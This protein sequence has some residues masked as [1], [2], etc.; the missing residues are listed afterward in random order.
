MYD[1]IQIRTYLGPAGQQEAVKNLL[2]ACRIPS[3]SASV[4]EQ[5][6][7]T[8]YPGLAITSTYVDLHLSDKGLAKK[9]DDLLSNM[10]FSQ[11]R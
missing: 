10:G 9:V 1:K 2:R 11:S 7:D 4:Y 6:H 3:H 5:N 8:G